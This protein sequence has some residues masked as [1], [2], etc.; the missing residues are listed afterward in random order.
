MKRIIDY[1]M[2]LDWVID[3]PLSKR[4]CI[5]LL[6]AACNENY[7]YNPPMDEGA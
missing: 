4:Q 5:S 1:N 3:E 7:R 2:I 6:K